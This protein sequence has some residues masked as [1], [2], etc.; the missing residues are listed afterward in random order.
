MPDET[1]DVASHPRLTE[2]YLLGELGERES[3]RFEE[4]FF[5]CRICSDEVIAASQ[6]L[7]VARKL[8][9]ARTQEVPAATSAPAARTWWK[10]LFLGTGGLVWIPRFA[11]LAAVP[12]ALLIAYDRAVLLPQVRDELA[13]RDRPGAVDPILLRPATRGK[14]RQIVVDAG[15][16]NVT[17]ALELPGAAAGAT[18]SAAVESEAGQEVI[19]RFAVASPRPTEPLIIQFPAHRLAPGLYQMIVRAEDRKQSGVP[20][21][22]LRRYPFAIVTR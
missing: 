5:N 10:R 9:R 11:A 15:T 3:A 21:L 19:P 17:V 1:M 7:N 18:L 12:M 6:L 8:P 13:L 14:V 20:P 4:H 2:Q 16:R 22:D